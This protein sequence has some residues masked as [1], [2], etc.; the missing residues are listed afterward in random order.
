MP[1]II[2]KI[3]Y[4]PP[5]TPDCFEI[6][7]QTTGKDILESSMKKTIVFQAEE[8]NAPPSKPNSGPGYL[9]PIASRER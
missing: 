8:L 1:R 3:K 4:L 5:P 6:G 7:T 2:E 9:R